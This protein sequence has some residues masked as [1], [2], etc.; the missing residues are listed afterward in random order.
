MPE[1]FGERMSQRKTVSETLLAA[2]FEVPAYLR[3][4]LIDQVK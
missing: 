2:R 4:V 3:A 1:T